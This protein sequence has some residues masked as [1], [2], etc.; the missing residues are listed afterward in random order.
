VVQWWPD[1][2]RLS[3]PHWEYCVGLAYLIRLQALS[4]GG[5]SRTTRFVIYV[6]TYVPTQV[7]RKASAQRLLHGIHRTYTLTIRY[8]RYTTYRGFVFAHAPAHEA[9]LEAQSL[10]YKLKYSAPPGATVYPVLVHILGR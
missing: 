1:P 9:C 4:D 7:R 3:Q 8:G 5:E 10:A 2:T 6:P